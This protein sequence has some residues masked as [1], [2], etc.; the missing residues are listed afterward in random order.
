[1]DGERVCDN[2]CHNYIGGY[3]CTCK[4]GYFLHDNQ[5]SCTGKS[6]NKLTLKRRVPLCAI[7]GS[8]KAARQSVA[9]GAWL[10]ASDCNDPNV[11]LGISKANTSQF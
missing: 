8:Q 9:F 4:Q 3:Y 7:K 6:I 1:M 10:A 5:R 2:F 11:L